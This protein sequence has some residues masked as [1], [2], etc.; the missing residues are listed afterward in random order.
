MNYILPR[1]LKGAFV[2]VM[3]A[4]YKVK[5]QS[6]AADHPL[7]LSNN[8]V[9]FRNV[10]RDH[11]TISVQ[12]GDLL[13]PLFPRLGGNSIQMQVGCPNQTHNLRPLLTFRLPLPMLR[14]CQSVPR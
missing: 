2:E 12:R 14:L 8:I 7:Q 4:Q 9:T 6:A 13:N 11:Q 3:I 1:C 5:G 10:T